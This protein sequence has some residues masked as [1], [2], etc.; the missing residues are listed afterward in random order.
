MAGERKVFVEKG[1]KYVVEDCKRC[2]GTG[3]RRRESCGPCGG[4]GRFKR[5]LKE[6]EK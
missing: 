4:T 3:Q 6:G 2:H 1:V 5:L